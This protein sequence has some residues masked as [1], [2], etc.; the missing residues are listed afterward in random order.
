[1]KALLMEEY[2]KL[3]YT[4]FP[5]PKIEDTQDILVR[6]KAVAI[7]GSDIHGFDGSTGRRKP[8]IIMG[9]EA[10]GEV[11]AVGK[12]VSK[13]KPGD[14]VTFDSTI[15]C[16]HCAF[17][18][19]GQF[20][21]CDNRMVIGVSCDEYRRHGAYAEYLAIPQRVCCH[22]PE[23]LSW[24]EAA[25]TEPAAVAAHAFRITPYSLNEN[26]AVVGCGLIGLLLIDI[27]KNAVSG[28]IIALDID[29]ARRQA[30]LLRGAAA[31]IDPQDA[32][33]GK[34]I[35]EMTAGRGADRVYEVVGASEPIQTAVAIT[36]KGGS[37]TLVGNVSPKIELPLQA[38][39]SRQIS[40]F[41][42]CAISGEYPLVLDLM[43]R[44]KIDVKSLISKT[45]PLSEGEAWMNKLYNRTENLLKVVLMP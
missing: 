41:G 37:V 26:I 17:C 42:S 31:A 3:N 44:K 18:L 36:R 4:D 30:A 14:R 20:N 12:D 25:M 29:P 45:A 38:V 40:L 10:A 8:P 43:G 9:H 35:A 15:F 33:C 6:I 22:L 39:V 28:K 1:M 24:E 34:K 7:C 2:K 23:G 27:L 32:D 13:F 19:A 16:G 21:L 5:E 11:V